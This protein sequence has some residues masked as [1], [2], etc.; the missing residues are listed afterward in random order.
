[1]ILQPQ[2]LKSYS[3]W[4]VVIYMALVHQG[5]EVLVEAC[6]V[7][8]ILAMHCWLSQVGMSQSLLFDKERLGL[9][10]AQNLVRLDVSF[11][12]NIIVS[13]DESICNWWGWEWKAPGVLCVYLIMWELYVVVFIKNKHNKTS[14][15][16]RQT[17]KISNKTCLAYL[18]KT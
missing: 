18:T 7:S 17:M 14:Q 8:G 6:C 16:T 9:A 1:M 10:I 5:E 2:K 13:S 15:L 11:C 12:A 4:A 3:S